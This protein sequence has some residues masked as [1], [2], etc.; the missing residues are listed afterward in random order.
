MTRNV[1]AFSRFLKVAA[2]CN[3]TIVNFS[4]VASDAQVARTTIYEYFEILKDTLILYEL[5]AW[6]LS[7]KRRY[8]LLTWLVAGGMWGLIAF[9]L[10]GLLWYR[11]RG[12]I[13][14]RAALDEGWVVATG[15]GGPEPEGCGPDEGSKVDPGAI[16]Q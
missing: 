10:A 7:I 5:P 3:G 4:N 13:P 8:S 15:E 9:S 16:P 11:R 1:P 12:D 14:R 6:R 2:L